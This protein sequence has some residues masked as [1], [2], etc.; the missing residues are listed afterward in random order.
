MTPI[1]DATHAA[2]L[3]ALH[4]PVLLIILFLGTL[5]SI[6]AYCFVRLWDGMRDDG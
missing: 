1:L 4:A 2:L 5:A 6:A 3:R